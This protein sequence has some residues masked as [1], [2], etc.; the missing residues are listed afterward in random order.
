MFYADV[1][2][3][4]EEGVYVSGIEPGSAAAMDDTV[5]VGDRLLRVSSQL[6]LLP[7]TFTSGHTVIVL[8]VLDECIT[9]DCHGLSENSLPLKSGNSVNTD[10]D[11]KMYLHWY[12]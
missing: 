7:Q 5:T 3:A 8:Y 11:V 4:V 9:A 6:S 2:I 10:E 12:S 1:G